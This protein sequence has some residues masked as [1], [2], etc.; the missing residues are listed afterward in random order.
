M[1]Y[2]QDLVF[3]FTPGVQPS[4]S[5][6]GSI[7]VANGGHLVDSL[8]QLN[9]EVNKFEPLFALNFLLVEFFSGLHFW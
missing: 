1:L 5:V 2:L 7:V 3:Y 4:K 9:S 6:L 8:H